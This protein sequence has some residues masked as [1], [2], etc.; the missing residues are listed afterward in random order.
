MV[1]TGDSGSVDV[2]PSVTSTHVGPYATQST[3][4]DAGVI[5]PAA[6]VEV[7][8]TADPPYELHQHTLADFDGDGILDLLAVIMDPTDFKNIDFQ[9]MV[10]GPLDDVHL[11]GDAWVTLH[12]DDYREWLTPIE[13]TGDGPMDLV[14]W[15]TYPSVWLRTEPYDGSSPPAPGWI[16]VADTFVQDESWITDIDGDGI[17]DQLR[18][19]WSQ[20]AGEALTLTRGPYQRFG[21]DPDVTITPTC[22]EPPDG[23][24]YQYDVGVWHSVPMGDL[25]GDGSLELVTGTYGWAKDNYDCGGFTVSLPESGTIDPFGS[26]RAV[27][28]LADTRHAPLGDWSGDQLPDLWNGSTNTMLMSPVALT[29][30][31]LLGSDTIDVA[32]VIDA[33]RPL[34]VDLDADGRTEV[35][36][37]F[38]EHLFAIVPPDPQQLA[39]VHVDLAW[40]IAHAGPE[41]YVDRGHAYVAF[42]DGWVLRRIDLG[43]ASTD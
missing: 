38:D 18:S 20:A 4:W 39:E 31:G 14:T 34:P 13:V 41:V 6:D 8:V 19:T 3:S 24:D 16:D 23:Q 36:I 15:G 17:A 1:G 30:D 22:E 32:P 33:I 40:D 2:G 21:G 11:P 29:P 42:D 7:F 26:P 27:P 43:V 12:E 25:D 28:G 37:E 9:M 35:L 10:L 5:V